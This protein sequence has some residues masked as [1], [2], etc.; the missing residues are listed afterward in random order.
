MESW[1]CTPDNLIATQ[2]T[3]GNLSSP[4]WHPGNT[5]PVIGACFVCFIPGDTPAGRK[6]DPGWAGA[7]F[8]EQGNIT[9]TAIVKGRAGAPYQPGLLALREG[10]LLETAVLAL[11]ELPDVLL[12]NATGRDHPRRS[13][14]ALHLGARL[15]VPTVGVTNRPLNAAGP[16]PGPDRGHT[17]PL[18]LDGEVVA[19]WLRTRA[20][21]HPLAIH[22]AWRTDAA[23]A[24]EVVL[25]ATRKART[26][27]PMR[28]AR[29]LARTARAQA[30]GLAPALK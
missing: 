4:L 23:T 7:V 8:W 22:A 13:G 9:A 21:A 25:S 19:V 2:E 5:P 6:D 1:P 12:T 15:Q 17:S 16:L 3:L 29:R 30:L 20:K 24:A 27:E 18:L 28:E 14:M 11:P 26:P 10:S